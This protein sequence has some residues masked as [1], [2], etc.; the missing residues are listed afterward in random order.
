MIKKV[1]CSVKRGEI[2][3]SQHKIH[4]VVINKKNHILFQS[5]NIH[6]DYCL[7]STLKPFQCA[8][9]LA[10]GT[11]QKYQ[12]STKE[13]AVTCASHHAEKEHINTIQTILKKLNLTEDNLECGF[14]FPLNKTNKTKLYSGAIKHSSIYNNCSGKHSGLLAMIKNLGFN[15]DGYIN[16]KHP[17]HRHI[18]NYI[19]KCAGIK[20]KHFAI[21]GCSLPTPYFSL[22]ILAGMYM[23]LITAPKNSPLS[24]L[25]SLSKKL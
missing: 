24:G 13:K 22:L 5:G 14:H 3:E 8:A 18:N 10:T 20:S 9:S 25:K 21:D 1:I 11:D 2:E 15:V 4:C 16:H 7:R 17:I 23:K 12:L 6:Q 19:E